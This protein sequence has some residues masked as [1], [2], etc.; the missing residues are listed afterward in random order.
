LA[1]VG[2]DSHHQTGW[3]QR[4]VE[5]ARGDPYK[6]VSYI[7]IG[8]NSITLIPLLVFRGLGVAIF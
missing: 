5:R 7:G 2:V 1:A 6:F 3:L 4:P 8:L